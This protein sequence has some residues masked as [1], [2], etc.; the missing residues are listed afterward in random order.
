MTILIN[1]INQELKLATPFKSIVSGTQKFIK[2][3]FAL[4]E[5]WDNILPFAQFVQNGVGY[6]AY[7]DSDNS[8]YLPSE[9]APGTFTLMLYG[10][11][12][13]VIG[14][15]NYLTI[16]VTANNYIENTDSTVISQRLYDQ[17]VELVRNFIDET[18]FDQL[19][20]LIDTKTDIVDF[21]AL[22]G[23]VSNLEDNPVQPEV[24]EEYVADTIDQMLRDGTLAHLTI[25]DG[26]VSRAKVDSDF[27]ATLDKADNSWQKSLTDTAPMTAGSWESIYDPNGYGK[28]QNPKDPYTYA[29]DIKE[30]LNIGKTYSLTWEQGG[31]NNSGN[32]SSSNYD[33]RVRST[34]Y[35]DI[36]DDSIAIVVPQGYK[37]LI[38]VYDRTNGTSHLGYLPSADDITDNAEFTISAYYPNA[39]HLKFVLGKVDNSNVSPTIAELYKFTTKLNNI[40]RLTDEINNTKNNVARN[41]ANIPV[42]AFLSAINRMC[43]CGAS[44]DSGYVYT[45][46]GSTVERSYIAWGYQLSKKYNFTF[47]CSARHSLYTKTW[48][49]SPYGIAYINEHDPCDLYVLT[50]G[51]NDSKQG[52][53]Y[54]GA[55]E[56]ITSHESYDDYADSFYG[57]YGRIVEQIKEHAPNALLVC[58][59]Y[60]DGTTARNQYYTALQNI[61]EHYHIPVFNWYEDEWYRTYLQDNLVGS[62]PTATLHSG[63]ALAFERIYNNLVVDNYDYFKFLRTK[64]DGADEQGAIPEIDATL[65]VAGKAADAKKTGD[66]ISS[67]KEDLN[68]ITGNSAIPMTEGYIATSSTYVDVTEV[69]DSIIAKH[70]VV[71]VAPGEVYT[72]NAQGTSPAR[73]YAIID[74]TGILIENAGDS[75][76]AQN[77]LVVIPSNGDKLIINDVG[78]YT[79]YRGTLLTATV[80]NVINGTK[81]L[82]LTWESGSIAS[83]TGQGTANNKRLRTQYA[84]VKQGDDIVL[85]FDSTVVLAY[86]FYYAT[87]SHG[88]YIGYTQIRNTGMYKIPNGVTYIRVVIGSSTDVIDVSFADNLYITKSD[89]IDSV[90]LVELTGDPVSL[91]INSGGYKTIDGVYTSTG[92]WGYSDNIPCTPGDYL[93][94]KNAVAVDFR[95]LFFYSSDGIC[96]GLYDFS[97]KNTTLSQLLVKVPTGTSYCVINTKVSISDTV[98]VSIIKS[99]LVSA[100]DLAVKSVE[101]IMVNT[102]FKLDTIFKSIKG[103]GPLFT[104]VDDDGRNYNQISNFHDVCV[105]NG[106][107]GCN[108]LATKFI[109]DMSQ[110]DR[111]TFLS[112]LK[113]YEHD[114]FENVLHCY[115]HDYWKSSITASMT[116]AQL[117]SAVTN[118]IVQGISEM[119]GYGFRNWRHWIVP[120]G[121]TN[122]PNVERV[123]RNLGVQ[124]A[125]DVANNTYNRFVPRGRTFHR[126]NVPRMELYSNDTANPGHTLQLIKDQAVICAQEGGWLIVCTHFYQQGWG[127]DDPTYS[128]V[129]DMIQYI[130][131]L[132]FTNVTLSGGMSYWEDVY[133]MYDLF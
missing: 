92:G 40:T 26:S 86:L 80:N 31:L 131:G 116:D 74:A 29:D 23:R 112:T 43:V 120:Q 37:L 58:G 64:G 110:S 101:K 44:W 6:N 130:M 51:G 106:I 71:N 54:L 11:G 99:Q 2:F 81:S 8:C 123:A 9:I 85:V 57:N 52:T 18:D 103:A 27:E 7:L 122:L 3:K 13:E 24:V 108:A 67:L 4:D 119:E 59:M 21:N 73:A 14:T 50:F 20:D 28:G 63:I 41:T 79:S 117:F 96:T 56:D 129:S 125:Y 95:P 49:T 34:S 111:D 61:C 88:S 97:P 60:N 33:I 32:T 12:G 47:V 1:V 35:V 132:G 39:T 19:R 127:T 68:I 72:I 5:I 66:E 78:G 77:R 45:E 102:G 107:I 84:P 17:L 91:T 87:S 98:S 48:L 70:A 126:Y 105:A 53:E 109:D 22:V 114:G 16:K 25:V 94:I 75:A 69:Y 124:A 65:S 46:Q 89:A 104:I 118:D 55:L 36:I 121:K 100:N 128:R 113:Q 30:D 42:N 82:N 133:R 15:T 93:L 62:H 76:L 38:H 90:H 83:A 10:S 115:N